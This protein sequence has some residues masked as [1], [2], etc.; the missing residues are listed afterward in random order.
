VNVS[1]E[2]AE[3]ARNLPF[4]FAVEGVGHGHSLRT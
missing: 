1:D 3:Q 2:P 4:L